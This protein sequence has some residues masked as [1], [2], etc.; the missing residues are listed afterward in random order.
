VPAKIKCTDGPALKKKLGEHGDGPLWFSEDKNSD[1]SLIYYDNKSWTLSLCVNGK[2]ISAL[3][4]GGKAPDSVDDVLVIGKFNSD[5]NKNG[6]PKFLV[7][8]R[9]C[10]EGPCMGGQDIYQVEGENIRKLYYVRG[11][12]IQSVVDKDRTAFIIEEGC[13][14]SDFNTL[15]DYM[16]VVDPSDKSSFSG[17]SGDKIREHFPSAIKVYEASINRSKLHVKEMAKDYPK[18]AAKEEKYIKIQELFLAAY[19]G[20]MASD[21]LKSYQD[22]HLNPDFSLNCNVIKIIEKFAKPNEKK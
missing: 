15:F 8:E 5:F 1:I 7:S 16:D 3:I 12:D 21:L 19:Q 4:N 20:K 10:A 17:L 11:N 14:D 2:P 6:K 9:Q 22:L 13:A 18:E